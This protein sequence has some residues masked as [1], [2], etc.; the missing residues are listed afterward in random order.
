MKTIANKIISRIYGHG[1]GWCFTPKHFGDLGSPEAIRINLH[2]LE[3]KGVIRRLAHGL[4][5]YPK[6]HPTIGLLSP[7]PTQIAQAIAERDETRI[8]PSGAYAANMLGLTEQIP[9]KSVF[10]TNGPGRIIKIGR[11]EI[12]LKKTSPRYLAT[13]S[14]TSSTL[15][16]ALRYLGK[17]QI[18]RHHINHLRKTLNESMK[19]QLMTDLIHSPYWMRPFIN[20]IVEHSHA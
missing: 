14:K 3:K 1:R 6:K 19:S 10:L 15:I 2:R 4:Y 20:E 7:S 11:Q 16:Q 17:N 12:Q 18:T 8:H 5:D 9:A 13:T